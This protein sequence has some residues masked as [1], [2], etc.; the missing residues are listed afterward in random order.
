MNDPMPT[1]AGDVVIARCAA[2]P[3]QYHVWI[4]DVD[5]QQAANNAGHVS[6]VGGR[7]P[8]MQRAARLVT[9]SDRAALWHIDMDTLTWARLLE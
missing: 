6:T 2:V 7:K 4:V 9:E 1:R 3:G 8:A 5:G